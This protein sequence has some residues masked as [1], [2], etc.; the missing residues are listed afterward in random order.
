M[1]NAPLYKLLTLEELIEIDA[2]PI[3]CPTEA[4]EFNN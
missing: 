1:Q 4:V 2:I 3:Y